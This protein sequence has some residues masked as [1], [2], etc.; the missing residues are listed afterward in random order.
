MKV[1]KSY[2]VEGVGVGKP[3]Y[4][5]VVHRAKEWKRIELKPN[6]K[7]KTFLKS[8]ST[9]S[10]E[11]PFVT[12]PLGSGAT[13]DL[14]DGETGQ[15]MPF[16]FSKAYEFEI[17]MLWISFNQDSKNLVYFDG[18]F[19][20]EYYLA[21]NTIYYESEAREFTSKDYDPAFAKGHSI[22][23]RVENLG[24]ADMSGYINIYDILRA[25]GTERPKTKIVK[26]GNCGTQREVSV[27]TTLWICPKCGEGTRFM[28]LPWGGKVV[29]R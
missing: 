14:M 5:R 26:C 28:Y 10:S 13:A 18:E 29:P 4:S 3:D 25:H 17:L 11:Y 6:E 15:D 12:S 8:F 27:A 9:I 22:R 19:V 23:F 2:K 16:S 7:I 1:E 20:G 24:A 21:A